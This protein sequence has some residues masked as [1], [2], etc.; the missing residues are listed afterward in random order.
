M[1]KFLAVMMSVVLM[2]TCTVISFAGTDDAQLQ[3]D[4]NGKFKILMIADFQDGAPIEEALVQF[5]N[6][7]LDKTEPDLVIFLG[8]NVMSPSDKTEESYWNAYDVAL[9]PVVSRDIPFTLVFGNHDDESMPDITKEEMLEKYM[10]YDGCLAYDAEPALHGCGTHNLEVLSSDGTHTALNLWMMDSGDYVYDENGDRDGYDCVRADQIEWYEQ[11]ADELA[12]ENGGTVP[13][14][15]FQHIVPQEVYEKVMM[16]SPF[17]LN[18]GVATKNFRDVSCYSAFMPNF[19]GFS[20]YIME[21]PCPS[22]DNDGQWESLVKTGDVKGV[23]FGHDHVNNYQADVNGVTAVS[24]PGATYQ[25]YNGV[26]QAVTLLTV[27]ENDVENFT[28]E[29]I[30]ASKLAV[31][32]DSQLAGLSGHSKTEYFFT[33]VARV[34]LCALAKISHILGFTVGH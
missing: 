20:G 7:A 32:D 12:E 22:L 8:D 14:L 21:P 3:F 1:K 6:E 2:L 27:D 25:S 11:K 34:L 30:Y 5:M 28:L 19:Y 9:E 17:N 31:E 18:M 29:N 13:A 33:N 24:V 23:F 15:M 26:Y 10:S 4:E 16:P